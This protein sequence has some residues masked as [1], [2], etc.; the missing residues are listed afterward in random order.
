[1]VEERDYAGD[2]DLKRMQALAVGCW[3]AE[4]P[5]VGCAI[6]DPPWRMY[7]HLDKLREVRVRLW[8]E[9]GECVA[10]GWLWSAGGRLSFLTHPGRRELLDSILGW[11]EPDSVEVLEHDLPS[12]SMLER[13]G[14]LLA[15]EEGWMNH[16]LRGLDNVPEPR[17]PDG[18]RLRTVRAEPDLAAR[19][20]VH[21]AAF[22]PSR[23]VPESYR[24]VT[25]AWPYR[26]ELDCVVEAPDGTFAAFCLCWL[27]EEN[28]VGE[29]EPVG[30]HP[31]HQRRGLATA[32]CRYAL[33]ALRS[34]GAGKA[35][36]Y[37]KAGY[38]ATGLYE[39]LGFETISRHLVYA[40]SR[41][42][43]PSS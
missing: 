9:R 6:G 40:A 20:E 26:P 31:E 8:L 16:M 14:Y 13:R 39:K 33:R 28:R 30:T 36:V 23:V 25:R 3:S 2:N 22:A 7:Q 43:T 4:G 21:R 32:A 15:E 18:Y 29:L 24:Q 5:L 35:V 19:V 38:K 11:S 1:M 41:R 17:V 37:S 27:D 34:A 42:G 12:R 10:W